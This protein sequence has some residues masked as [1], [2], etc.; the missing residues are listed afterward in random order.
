V[1][2][3]VLF[4]TAFALLTGFLS[5]ADTAQGQQAKSKPQEV[6][7]V[8]LIDMAYVFK[9]YKKFELLRDDLK[10]EITASDQ[11][12]S[13]KMQQL[14]ALQEELKEYKE[15]SPNFLSSEEKLVKMTGEFESFRKVAQRD[16][17]RK[18][19]EIYKTIYLEVSDA[20]AKGADYF[21]YT[22]IIRFNRDGLDTAS[23]PQE[24]IKSMNKQVV[25]HRTE[26]DITASVLEFLND[27]YASKTKSPRN[28]R[29]SPRTSRNT[30]RNRRTK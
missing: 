7:K 9:N 13:A 21:G 27:Q 25:F 18:E 17:M 28:S 2:K 24:V 6:H 3:V 22:L 30:S 4:V 26:D 16:F 20:V 11:Q 10:A 15:G 8:G 29:P 14:K 23:N 19:A 5:F 12:A 1:K